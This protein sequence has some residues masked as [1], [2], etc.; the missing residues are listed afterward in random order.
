MVS[1]KLPDRQFGYKSTYRNSAFYTNGVVSHSP[2]APAVRCTP[3]DF[4]LNRPA[5]CLHC[6]TYVSDVTFRLGAASA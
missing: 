1:F 2:V 3:W 6:L 4:A 5:I